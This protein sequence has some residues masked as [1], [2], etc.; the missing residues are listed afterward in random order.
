MLNEH[1]RDIPS[2]D[3]ILRTDNLQEYIRLYSKSLVTQAVR[4]I[5]SKMRTEIITGRK[6]DISMNNIEMLVKSYLEDVFR[7]SMKKIVNASGIILHTN[8]GR[9]ILCSSAVEAIKVCVR[10][11]VNLE[12]NLERGERGERDS[13]VEG[14]ICR[15]TGAEAAAVVNNNAAAIFLTLNTLAEQKE[16]IISRGELIEIGGSFR[17]PEVIQK[18]GCKLIE[19][20]T[21]NRTHLSDY[22]SAISHDTAAILK[23][24]TS[25][26]RVIGFTASVDLKELAAIGS[27]HDIPI[28]EDLG[29]G[30]LVDLSQFGLP[31][32]PTVRET[33][34]TGVD[35]VT[36]SGDKLLGGPQV[37]IIVGKR[38]YIWKINKNP[39]K[40][41]LRVDKITIAALEATLK[42]YL[43]P[44]SL[45][46]ELPTLRFLTRPI[47]EIISVAEKA[48]RLLKQRLGRDYIVEIENGE[49]QIG[50]GSLPEEVIPTKIVSIAHKEI[51]PEKIFDIF[52]K[53]E[54]PVLGRVHKGKFLLDIRMIEK[55]EDVA[56]SL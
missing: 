8:L 29:S 46:T 6:S 19:V 54:P 44:D 36:F 25:N 40:R 13:H 27:H 38:K 39:L 51:S 22:T 20:G 34:E 50:S 12:F 49:S 28:V 37:G 16:V 42:L 41:A 7:A 9:A 18:S 32:E 2:I 10:N 23:A 21:T 48:A 33:I 55:A 31:R 17:I 4:D 5:L 11:P 43:N 35:I 14:L 30:S 3:E 15:L 47:A 56:I 26:Y 45:Q 53:N 24:H 1:L 52:L